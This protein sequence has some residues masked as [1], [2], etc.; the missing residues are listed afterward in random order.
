MIERA[1]FKKLI[2]SVIERFG[3]QRKSQSW[4]RSSTDTT[5]LISLQKSDF[6]NK[7][8]LNLG[9]WIC[10]LG[11][12]D[13]PA[14]NKCHLQIR[15]SSAI[16]ELAESLEKGGNLDTASQADL[17][18]L[19]DAIEL[20]VIPFCVDCLSLQS[21]RSKYR[22]GQFKKGLVHKDAKSLLLEGDA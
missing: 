1:Q 17:A 2:G 3:F 21:L 19:V 8:Y 7:Y 10:A 12:C 22:D 16:E 18:T 14:E 11:R 13:Y 5:V 9:V 20:K 6:Q 15:A 4:Y